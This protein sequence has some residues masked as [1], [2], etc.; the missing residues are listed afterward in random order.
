MISPDLDL[1]AIRARLG[2]PIVFIVAGQ[3][4]A[5]YEIPDWRRSFLQADADRAALLTALERIEPP[6]TNPAD[7]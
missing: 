7:W 3:S 4:G 1:A 5:P 6:I 2:Q